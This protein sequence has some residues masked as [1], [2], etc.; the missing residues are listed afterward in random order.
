MLDISSH[1]YYYL[2]Y[3]FFICNAF[4]WVFLS[5]IFSCFQSQSIICLNILLHAFWD[6]EKEGRFLSGCGTNENWQMKLK[7]PYIWKACTEPWI[8]NRKENNKSKW[9]FWFDKCSLIFLCHIS[10]FKRTESLKNL[11]KSSFRN[12]VLYIYI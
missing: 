12:L 3:F 9:C 1:I 10:P 5:M 11:P 8:C 7:I 4:S 6:Q 2:Y